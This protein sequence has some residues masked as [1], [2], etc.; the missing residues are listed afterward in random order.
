MELEE[1]KNI[2]EGMNKKIEKQELRTNH[3]V[4][5]MQAQKY[6]SQLNKIRY[7]E[8]LGAIICYLGALY[9][10]FNFEKIEKTPEMVFAI[11]TI[12]LLLILPVI[13]LRYIRSMKNIKL[14][15]K[16]Y[17][18]TINDFGKRKIRF[19]KFQKLNV[20][21]GLFVILTGIPVLSAI[22]GKELSETAHFWTLIFPIAVIAFLGFAFW[23]LRSYNKAFKTTEQMLSDINK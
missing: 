6:Q 12:G 16:T 20:S 23:V 13:S 5:K 22:R 15:S 10:I 8:L 7:S 11:I 9:L 18:E 1:M 14:S 4:E 21:L 17:L 2:W 3:L 19:Q